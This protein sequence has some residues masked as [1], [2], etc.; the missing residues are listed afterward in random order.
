VEGGRVTWRVAAEVAADL[1]D[2]VGLTPVVLLAPDAT[3]SLVAFFR[4]MYSR[5]KLLPMALLNP[6]VASLSFFA[7]S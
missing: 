7:P 1:F 5:A 6:L 4:A 2:A 3:E